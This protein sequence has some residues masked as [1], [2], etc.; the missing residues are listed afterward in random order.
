MGR[1][2]HA[3]TPH[4]IRRLPQCSKCKQEFVLVMARYENDL[5]PVWEWECMK[6]HKYIPRDLL[7]EELSNEWEMF[8][9]EW[10]KNEAQKLK[11]RSGRKSINKYNK[12]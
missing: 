7:K 11:K 2:A 9:A 10:C 4:K 8:L 5:K 6:C 12:Q 3:K 1:N